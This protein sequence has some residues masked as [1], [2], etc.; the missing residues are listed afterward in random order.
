VIPVGC[1]DCETCS[2]MRCFADDCVDELG[3]D[4]E[5]YNCGGFAWGT[6][7]WYVP[8]NWED[9][10]FNSD[11]NPEDQEEE[12]LYYI[13][14]ILRDIQNVRIIN[15]ESELKTGESLV[16][17]RF[18]SGDFHFVRK[19]E[20]R[21]LHKRGWVPHIEEMDEEEVYGTDW[22][23]GKYDSEITM[24]AYDDYSNVARRIA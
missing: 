7:D 19:H 8:S 21:Y 16:L 20:G 22:C 10:Y 11:W 2:Q 13:A 24:F 4:A 23:D 15:S 12:R 17:F 6:R 3:Y 14:A 1:V 5:H 18:G 9:R